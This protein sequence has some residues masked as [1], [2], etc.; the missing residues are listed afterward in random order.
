[1]KKFILGL[2]SLFCVSPVFAQV[3]TEGTGTV[4]AKPDC[5]IMRLTATTDGKTATDAHK[6]TAS[7]TKALWVTLSKHKI[8]TADVVSSGLNISRTFD[9]DEKQT[10]FRATH[11]VNVTMNNLSDMG[12]FVDDVIASGVNIDGFSFGIKDKTELEKQA[13]DLALANAKAKAEQLC[14]GLG[15]K[16]GNVKSITEIDSRYPI[17]ENGLADSLGSRIATGEKGITVFVNVT[18]NVDCSKEMTI[19][20]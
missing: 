18:W 13:R 12:S 9:K 8:D 16:L 15:A 4:Y 14:K 1:M 19:G 10:G 6:G 7:A 5:A 3:S 17:F 11:R 2:V 20:R